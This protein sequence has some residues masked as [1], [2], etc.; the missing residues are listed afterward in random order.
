HS[1]AQEL[2]PLQSLQSL[3]LGLYLIPST[4]ILA[5]RVYHRRNMTSPEIIQWQHAV[6]LA[7]LS[8]N[9]VLNDAEIADLPSAST[10]Q[11]SSVIYQA[12]PYEEFGLERT[13]ESCTESISQIGRDAETRANAILKNLL[14]NLTSVEWMAW[15][16]PNHLGV[17]AHRL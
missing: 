1:L 5:H 9:V 3:R 15:L 2:A 8:D 11:L 12:D 14:P 16:S 17:N 6:A 13:C 10:N 7:G 4:T